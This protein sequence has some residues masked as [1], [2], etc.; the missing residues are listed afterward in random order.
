LKGGPKAY[1]RAGATWPNGRL[2]AS[3]PVAAH[4]AAEIS[5]RLSAA[6]AGRSKSGVAEA[7]GVARSTLYDVLTGETWPDLVTIA[8]LEEV[9]ELEL[10]PRWGVG[11][12]SGE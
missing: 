7:A 5:R 8:A 6:L 9:L 1:L 3:A 11:R 10:W 2:L 4:W 12:T